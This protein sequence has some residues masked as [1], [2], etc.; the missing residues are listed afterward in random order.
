MQAGLN[1]FSIRNY[2]DTEEHFLEA[3][4][5][6]KEMGYSYIQYSGGAFDPDRIA[7]V[8]KA[9]ELPVVLTHVPMD[10]IINDTQA[11]ME[12][13]DKFGC[14]NIGL[15]AMPFDAIADEAKC[16]SIVESLDR[17]GEV[18][19][20]NGFAF[21]YHHHHFEFFKHGDQTVFDYIVEKAPHINLTLDT[22]WL[23]FGGVD[24]G[25]TVDRLAGRIGCV[26][27][28]DYMIAKTEGGIAGYQPCFAPVG[29]G[30]IDYVSLVPRMK[31][32]GAQY[33]LVEQDNAA[34]LPDPMGQVARSI[35]Y[36]N[37]CL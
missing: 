2:L 14:K 23:Q 22:Y 24:I 8:S 12:E 4:K 36:I 37:N 6:L 29:D 28:K 18:M 35:H 21:F 32:A 15:G 30:N 9:A 10:R 13:H 11:L 7:R 34:T 1:L 33:F 19:Q 26:H 20:K 25:A 16:K 5:A 17:A 31:A 27:L 3:A